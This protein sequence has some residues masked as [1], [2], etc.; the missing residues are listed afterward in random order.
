[1]ETDLCPLRLPGERGEPLDG[2]NPKKETSGNEIEDGSRM[3]TPPERKPSEG[4]SSE[5]KVPES[6]LRE[7]PEVPGGETSEDE[8]SGERGP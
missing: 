6:A 4:E 2:E 3:E 1:M 7:R 8:T 5:S